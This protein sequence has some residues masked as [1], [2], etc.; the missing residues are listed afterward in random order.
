MARRFISVLVYGAAFALEKKGDKEGT[1][2]CSLNIRKEE[3]DGIRE[4]RRYTA[5]MERLNKNIR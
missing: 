4:N 2:A 3:S 1:L 5:K